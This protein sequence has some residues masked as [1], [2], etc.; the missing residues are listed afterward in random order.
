VLHDGE[1]LSAFV[2][3][4]VRN[5]VRMRLEPSA[6][7]ARGLASPEAAKQSG[8]HCEAHEVIAELRQRLEKA[9]AKRK[10]KMSAGR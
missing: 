9:K 7:I 2:E 6:F 5:A 8:R 4:S 3:A 10:L 1:S